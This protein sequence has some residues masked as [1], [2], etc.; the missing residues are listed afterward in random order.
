MPLLGKKNVTIV[1]TGAVKFE[2]L[3]VKPPWGPT[4]TLMCPG[5]FGGALGAAAATAAEEV[6][7]LGAAGPGAGP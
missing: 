1:P 4:S 5:V 3:N 6:A 7:A 2:G